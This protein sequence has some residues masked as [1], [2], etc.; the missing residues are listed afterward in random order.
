MENI[1]P[2]VIQQYLDQIKNNQGDQS[3]TPTINVFP[4]EFI[5]L[6]STIVIAM[7]VIAALFLLFYIISIIRN[8]K[9]QSAVM[10]MQKDV[11]EIKTALN[12]TNTTSRPQTVIDSDTQKIA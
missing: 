2:S 3:F 6:L 4:A 1:D 12:S 8:W 5:A 9:V 11:K 7:A 10:N